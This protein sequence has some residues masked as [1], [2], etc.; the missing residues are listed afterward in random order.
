[1]K[2]IHFLWISEIQKSWKS[3]MF[4]V[5]RIFLFLVA[6][7]FANSAIVT[8]TAYAGSVNTTQRQGAVTGT[9]VSESGEPIPG[10]TVMVKGT[11]NGT[12]TDFEWYLYD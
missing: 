3:K 6:F 10:A 1:M 11:T 7:T 9:V 8:S 12:I 5:S 4:N 2:R